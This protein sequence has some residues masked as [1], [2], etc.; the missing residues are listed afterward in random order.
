MVDNV[1][2]AA[3]R[4]ARLGDLVVVETHGE[5]LEEVRGELSTDQPVLGLF[6]FQVRV[7]DG[8]NAILG[9][10]SDLG[11]RIV[12][13][14]I[15]LTTRRLINRTQ[16]RGDKT[17]TV[18]SAD[19]HLLLDRLPTEVHA[20]LSTGITRIGEL[21]ITDRSAHGEGFHAGELEIVT[22]DRYLNLAI[23]GVSLAAG[24]PRDGRVERSH[25]AIL[26][27]EVRGDVQGITT[28]L[29]AEGGL[30]SPTG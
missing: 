11:D 29:G 1:L 7:V 22:K 27:G 4:N 14:R 19:H 18:G 16:G 17:L 30:D 13:L 8:E 3:E 15:I 23:H 20:R 2:F 28:G 10:G 26:E 24:S 25:R 6:G 21:L 5:T 9:L 12:N